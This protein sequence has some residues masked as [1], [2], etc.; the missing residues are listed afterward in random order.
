MKFYTS[1]SYFIKNLLKSIRIYLFCSFFSRWLSGARTFLFLSMFFFFGLA[2]VA[3]T[4]CHFG[5]TMLEHLQL[6]AFVWISVCGGW[7]F[8]FNFAT[9]TSGAV[10]RSSHVQTPLFHV[11][12]Q[13]E[14]G[15]IKNF[16]LLFFTDTML[17]SS[18]PLPSLSS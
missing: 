14:N 16:L 6:N 7:I 18:S 13:M 12:N 4:F 17:S 9:F 1:V 8:F 3:Y 11:T 10:H 15:K 2:L 5:G